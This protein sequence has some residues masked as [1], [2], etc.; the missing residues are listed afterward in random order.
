[1]RSSQG[2]QSSWKGRLP[3]RSTDRIEDAAAWLL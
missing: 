2:H 1:V 3:R